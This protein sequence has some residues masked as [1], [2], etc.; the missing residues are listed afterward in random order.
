MKLEA[1]YALLAELTHRCPLRCPYCYNP[2][3]LVRRSAELDTDSWKSV[4]DQAAEM[5]ILQVHMSGGEPTARGDIE[6]LVAHANGAGLYTNLIT[7]GVLS[8]EEQLQRLAAAGLAHVQISIQDSIADSGDWIAGYAG[9]QD[10]KLELAA[11][12][13]S[14]GLAL[15]INAVVHRQNIERVADMIDLAV[16]MGAQRVEVA[17]VQYYGWGIRNRRYLM[18][19]LEQLHRMHDTVLRKI[20]ALEGR[21]VIDYVVPDYYARRPKACMNGWGRRFI[22][23]TPEGKVLPCHAA[24][25]IPELEFDNVLDTPLATIWS[26]SAAFNRF[27][28]TAW[29]PEPCSSCDRREIDWGGCRCQALALTGSAANPDP[30]CELVPGHA[31]VLATAFEDSRDIEVDFDYRNFGGA[32]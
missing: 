29:M 31:E 8:D 23:V 20:D 19:T 11:K 3:E 25:T 9:A 26:D 22:N 18:P 27:R 4:F 16:Q 30:V 5:G 14:A 2:V 24:E 21:I 28:G 13:D 10:K 12:V 15:T 6:E 1:P 32:S 7:S 17:N